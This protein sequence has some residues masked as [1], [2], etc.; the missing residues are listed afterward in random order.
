MPARGQYRQKEP[1]STLL[2]LSIAIK[3]VDDG[4]RA[5]ITPGDIHRMRAILFL[6]HGLELTI[7]ALLSH[8][9]E[10]PQTDD[11][12]ELLDL[13]LKAKPVTCERSA[14]L[15]AHNVHTEVQNHGAIPTIDQARIAACA[16]EMFLRTA[17]QQV[18]GRTLEQV[19]V[20][21]RIREIQHREFK[22]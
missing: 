6:N 14:L 10:K 19:A 18:L 15:A 11:V 12:P 21:E 9:G 20:A 16:V 1:D 8:V 2:R 13:L 3:L 22:E 5:S 4:I 7:H 17:V